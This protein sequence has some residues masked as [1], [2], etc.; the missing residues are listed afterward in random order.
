LAGYV[1]AEAADTSYGKAP[2]LQVAER[3]DAHDEVT[4]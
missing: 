2:D 3:P 4:A 1:S